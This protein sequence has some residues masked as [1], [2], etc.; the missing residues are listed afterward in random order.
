MRRKIAYFEQFPAEWIDIL[1]L[2]E[3]DKIIIEFGEYSRNITEADNRN[4]PDT[5]LVGIAVLSFGSM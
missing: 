3:Y 2:A 4:R 1:L 5:R